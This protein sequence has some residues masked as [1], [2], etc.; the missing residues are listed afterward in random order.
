MD[1]STKCLNCNNEIIGKFCHHCGQKT[2]THRITAKHF[3]IHDLL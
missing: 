2:D 3:V 1:H